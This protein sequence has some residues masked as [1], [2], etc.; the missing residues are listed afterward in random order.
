MS[1]IFNKL[2]LHIV[3]YKNRLIIYLKNVKIICRMWMKSIH[4]INFLVKYKFSTFDKNY[5]FEFS[6]DLNVIE[7]VFWKCIST[8]NFLFYNMHKRF[9]ECE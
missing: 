7:S 4:N 5:N 2:L 1:F 9:V 8:S 6:N 3:E